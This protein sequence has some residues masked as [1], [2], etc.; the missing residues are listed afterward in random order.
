VT[1]NE[2][3][4]FAFRE[5]LASTE[6]TQYGP[7]HPAYEI[8]LTGSGDLVFTDLRS[9]AAGLS[10][11]EDVS[12][13]IYVRDDR[14][15]LV[16]ELEKPYGKRME[17]GLPPGT[18]ALSYMDRDMRYQATA[19]VYRGGRAEIYSAD[20]KRSSTVAAVAR[21]AAPEAGPEPE[22]IP[23]VQA[24]A[25]VAPPPAAAPG[26]EGAAAAEAAAEPA[27]YEG[28][29][30]IEGSGGKKVS[31]PI[32]FS[33][34]FAPDLS[35]GVFSSEKDKVV[36]LNAFVGMTRNL[37]GVELSTLFNAA[38]GDVSGLQFSALANA[39][40]GRAAGAQI[41]GIANIALGGGGGAQVGALLSLAK[42]DYYGAQ[43]AAANVATGRMV[44]AQGGVFNYASYMGGPQLGLVNVLDEGFAVQVGL[45]NA[46]DDLMGVQIGLVNVARRVDGLAIGLISIEKGGILD[47]EAWW[48]SDST[49]NAAF[50]AGTR[51]TY[52]IASAG[53]KTRSQEA[54][55]SLALGVGGRVQIGSNYINTDLSWRF[56][57]AFDTGF[58]STLRLRVVAGLRAAGPGLILGCAVD[59]LLPG[60]SRDTSGSF[61]SDLKLEPLLIV[62]IHL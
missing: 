25:E 34:F 35:K 13:R 41:S 38:S 2:A 55:L 1:L 6:N 42:G 56:V 57:D 17:L 45:V 40:K 14:G 32:S 30:T 20:F 53:W 21:G 59:A 61:V 19:S 16:V 39:A 10:L 9:S 47:A 49:A 27:A 8:S 7:Q 31:F 50:M 4:A 3:Y 58:F 33:A 15:A 44:G 48:S 26:A 54:P 5:T 28:R 22:S 12:G 43:V 52:T 23:G 60:I 51:H 37:R 62:G 24:G 36:G 46:C 11:G 18:Y 29:V